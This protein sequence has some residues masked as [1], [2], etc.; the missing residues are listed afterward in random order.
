MSQLPELIKRVEAAMDTVE[1]QATLHANREH[2]KARQ[3][4]LNYFILANGEK[5]GGR[6]YAGAIENIR[7]GLKCSG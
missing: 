6:A 7:K 3:R 4:L 5:E 2:L 1:K